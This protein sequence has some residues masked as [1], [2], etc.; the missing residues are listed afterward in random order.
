[1]VEVKTIPDGYILDYIDQTPRPDTPEEYVRQNIEKRLVLEHGYLREQIR[2]EMSVKV[3][4]GSKKRV[5]L[6]VFVESEKKSQENIHIIIETKKEKIQPTDKTDGIEQLKSYMAACLNCEWGMWTNGKFKTVFRKIKQSDNKLSFEEFNDI[7]SKNRPITEV[8]H[9]TRES[10]KH[11]TEDNLLFS[12]KTSHN[13]IYVNEGLQKQPAFFELLKIIFCK[14]LDEKEITKPLE[15]YAISKEKT[16]PDG[17]LTVKNRISKIFDKVKKKYPTIFDESDEL[18]LKPI[19]VAYIVS[20]LQKYNF[21]DTVVDVK[22]K[23]YE[24]I[25]GANLRGARG[26]FFT[27]RN[28][29]KMTIKMLDISTDKTILDPTCGTGGFL[30]IAMNNV[31]DKVTKEYKKAFGKEREKWSFKETEK[32][33]EKINEIADKN[34]FGFDINPDL[35]KSTKMNMVMNNDGSG[36]IL[37][38]DSLLPPHEMSVEIKDRLCNKFGL[39]KGSI[40]STKD[41]A[42]FDIIVANP[43]FGSKIKIPDSNVLEQFDLGYIWDEDE[44]TGTL[45]KTKKLHKSRAPEVLFIERCWQFLVPGGMMGIVLPDAI[46]GAPG[47]DNAAI[48]EWIIQHCRI[49][50][51][52]DLHKDTFEPGNG[53]K[54]SVLFLEKKTDEQIKNEKDIGINNYKIFFGIVNKMGHDKRGNEVYKRDEQGNDLLEPD[55]QI[56]KYNEGPIELIPKKRIR[57]DESENIAD[58]FLK[59]KN[60]EG[61]K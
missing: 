34:F 45:Y 44:E 19:T 42:L 3:G 12:F 14:I 55:P 48:R 61:I 17:R 54:T 49:I 8:D 31:I 47:K 23:A 27:P 43:P 59:W 38:S 46:L 4:S 50:A 26:E 58:V 53:T 41:L 57:D 39:K 2:V 20:E 21:I 32:F 9:P 52:I 10:L 5:D 28:I 40:T 36:N 15:F 11:A 13:F 60:K 24:E 18:N 30:V 25:V 37:Q 35:V 1:M 6:A 29:C 56:L 33:M 7:P 22:G 16:S 51:S